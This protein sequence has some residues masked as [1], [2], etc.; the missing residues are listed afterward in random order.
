ML[1]ICIIYNYMDVV[2]QPSHS[3]EKRSVLAWIRTSDV[4]VSNGGFDNY[5]LIDHTTKIFVN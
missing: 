2:I 1:S 3:T 5:M 4:W